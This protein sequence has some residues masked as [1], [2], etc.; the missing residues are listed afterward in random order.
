MGFLVS[1]TL[2]N[3]DLT[4]NDINRETLVEIYCVGKL[5]VYTFPLT[6]KTRD[7]HQHKYKEPVAKIKC[8]SYHTN[9]FFDAEN[10]HR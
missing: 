3:Y 9:L 6:Y 4:E 8:V 5:D 2:I 7:K 1:I 10:P